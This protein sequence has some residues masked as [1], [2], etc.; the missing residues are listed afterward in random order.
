M[1]T[2][3]WVLASDISFHFLPQCETIVEHHEDEIIEFFAHETE[4]VKDKLCSKRTGRLSACCSLPFSLILCLPAQYKQSINVLII[5]VTVCFLLFAFQT[6]VTTLWKCHMMNFDTV[7]RYE[8][9]QCVLW[10]IQLSPHHSF[11]K[12]VFKLFSKIFFLKRNAACLIPVIC[13]NSNI[14]PTSLFTVF[15]PC[16]SSKLEDSY[17]ILITSGN[18]KTVK[19]KTW[20]QAYEKIEQNLYIFVCVCVHTHACIDIDQLVTFKSES[21]WKFIIIHV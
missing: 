17:F 16:L 14:R 21:K 15:T 5:S 7:L 6:S 10:C 4:N 11:D 1:A 8:L 2:F 9:M 12:D 20:G 18:K 19:M 13:D 3:V